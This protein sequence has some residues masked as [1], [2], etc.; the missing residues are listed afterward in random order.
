LFAG[1]K[2]TRNE[3]NY[4]IRKG[5]IRGFHFDA[6]DSPDLFPVLAALAAYADKPSKISGVHRLIHKESN[7]ALVLQNEFAKC[8]I[9]IVLE[10][11]DMIIKPGKPGSAA[12]NSHGDHRIAMALAILALGG[13]AIEIDNAECVSKSYPDF[14][15][16][17]QDL[18]AVIEI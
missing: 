2:I 13:A 3:T 14:W 15:L 7:R 16:H 4:I 17:L 9:E 10:N 18:G 6:T 5:S 11:D 12:C 1:V 8:G